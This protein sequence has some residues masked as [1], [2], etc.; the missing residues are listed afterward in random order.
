MF[1]VAL[2]KDSAGHVAD[3]AFGIPAY[4]NGS[5]RIEDFAFPPRLPPSCRP[6]VRQFLRTVAPGKRVLAVHNETKAEKVWPRDRLIRLINSFLERHPEFVIFILDFHKPPA[7][8]EKF[9][10]RVIHSAHLPLHYAFAVLGESD[11]FLGVDSCMLHAA[12]LYRIPGVGLFGPAKIK[13]GPRNYKYQE[14]GFRFSPHRHIWDARGINHIRE[15][16]VLE[17]LESL[18][19]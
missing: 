6:R 4:F 12:D 13:F 8:T 15:A 18:L 7:S 1:A 10:D 9:K 19:S 2:P 16:I 17:A 11:L 14:W 3:R 5:L